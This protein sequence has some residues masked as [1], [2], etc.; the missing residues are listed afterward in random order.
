MMRVFSER[1]QQGG[2]SM[3]EMIVAIGVLTVLL[4]AMMTFISRLQ[5]RYT[6]EQRLSGINQGGK[7]AMDLLTIDIA[8]AGYPP[9]TSTSTTQAITGSIAPQ[10]VNVASIT[11]LYAGRSIV[12][13]IG[14]S[15]EIVALTAVTAGSPAP[16][17]SVTGIFKNGHG[18]P[19]TIGVSAYPYPQGVLFL[20]ANVGTGVDTSTNTALKLVGDI[21]GDGS[22]RYIEYRYSAPGTNTAVCG[23]TAGCLVRS[24]TDAFQSTESAAVTVVDNLWDAPGIFSYTIVTGGTCPSSTTYPWITCSTSGSA[25]S[26]TYVTNVG[27]TLTMQTQA[28][29]ERGAG[30]GGVRQVVIRQ[31]YFM[32]RNVM[33][34]YR[35]AQDGLQTLLPAAPGTVTG[36]LGQ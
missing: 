35:L 1:K 3:L 4:G 26:Y 2:F 5:E 12:I 16:T 19:A 34:A 28:A 36:I 29:I 13:G 22:L 27:V 14:D 23:P 25:G 17:G 21:R 15:Q 6:S 30:A 31:Q 32:P 10:T 11:G 9:V 33:S 24:D 8:Q 20:P 18:N 7:T